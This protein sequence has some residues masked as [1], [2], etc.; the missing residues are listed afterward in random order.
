MKR[1]SFAWVK[2]TLVFS[3]FIFAGCHKIDW[4][5]VWHKHNP[6]CQVKKLTYYRESDPIAVNAVFSYN[7]HGQPTKVVYDYIATGRPNIVFKYDHSGRLTDYIAPYDNNNYEV[8]F[9]YE[10]DGSGR[11]VSDTQF[12]FGQYIDS[13]PLPSTYLAAPGFYEYDIWGRVTQETRHYP[14]SN[15]QVWQYEYNSAGNL[16]A[17]KSFFNGVPA[18][19][20]NITT[21]DTKVSVL[22]TNPVWMFLERNYSKNNKIAATSYNS[23]GLPTHFNSP[24]LHYRFV[25]ETDI[26][27]SVIEYKCK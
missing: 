4:D 22:R 3:L 23:K 8:W 10:Y 27:H 19:T 24:G 17:I 6:N 9:K 16:S 11:I 5:D 26:S 13:V 20:E 1:N 25:H 7:S 15:V 18:G 21:Y 14:M 2:Y 12:V